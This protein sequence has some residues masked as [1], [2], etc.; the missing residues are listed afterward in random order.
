[1][2]LQGSQ[3]QRDFAL[4]TDVLVIGSGSGGAVVA[5]DLAR[6]G[7]EVVIVEEGRYIRPEVYG[8]WRPSQTLR[9]I[10]RAGG[11]TVALGIGDSPT[12]NI[13]AG[14][15]VGGSS[16]LT[17]GVCFRIPEEVHE[18]WVRSL[19]TASLSAEAMAPF[20]E[21]IETMSHVSPVPIEMRTRGTE[22]FAKGAERLGREVFPISRNTKGC[23]GCS[24]CNFGCPNQAKLSVDLTFLPK[25]QAAGARI[26]SDFR[27]ERILVEG[28]RAVGAEGVILREPDRRAAHRFTIRAKTV[29][30]A[31]GTL[32]SPLILMRSRIGRRSGQVG[33]DITLHPAFRVGAFFDDP[34]YNWRGALQGA[35]CTHPTDDRLIFIGASAP[36]NFLTATVPGLGPAWVQQLRSQMRHMATFGGMVHDKAG[37]RIWT[38]L[39]SEPV[40]TYRL[41][42]QDKA[43]MLEGMRFLAEA[44]FAAGAREVLLPIIGLEPI[45]DM[46][47]LRHLDLP[48]MPGSRIECLSFHPLGSCRMGTDPHRAVVDVEGQCFDVQGLWIADGSVFPSSVGV[49]TQIPVMTMA[50][51]TAAA[52]LEH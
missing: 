8:Q 4:E 22:L 36:V 34:I 50:A 40:I 23:C 39:G 2:I 48:S 43:S 47:Q 32:H 12:I 18:E 52:I 5:H 51:R 10:G 24:R 25:A 7:R 29:V 30:M 21:H 11:T 38:R 15:C 6:A 3:L 19:K 33:R 46:D 49:N 17:G 44:F 1:M 16:V 45:K 27:V 9:R 26:F 20:Y 35:Y 41:N 13:L 42:P 28:G 31:A 14:S 37:G